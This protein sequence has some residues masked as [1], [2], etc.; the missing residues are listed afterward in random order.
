MISESGNF[1]FVI[2]R[3]QLRE[4]TLAGGL[5]RAEQLESLGLIMIM[6]EVF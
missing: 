4:I 2:I 1:V 5:I 6:Q 3:H